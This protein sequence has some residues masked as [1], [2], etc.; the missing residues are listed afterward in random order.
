ME[1]N[2]YNLCEEV[3][4]CFTYQATKKNI[5]YTFSSIAKDL[6]VYG[7]REKIE[8]ALFNLI[9]N[10]IRHTP[11]AGKVTLSLTEHEE[12]V[13]ILVA[14]TGSGIAESTGDK[15]FER[16]Y[17]VQNNQ[18]YTNGGFGI[19]LLDFTWKKLRGEPSGYSKLPKY[20]R[21]WNFL[22]TNFT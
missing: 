11:E 17:K 8:I 20:S 9:S 7:D 4:L 21:D 12:K 22:R 1:L 18:N 5:N 2:L 13:S 16:F 6:T 19:G 15:I 10:A 14:D 3:F